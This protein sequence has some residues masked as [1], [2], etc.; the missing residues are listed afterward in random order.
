MKVDFFAVR[1]LAWKILKE[2]SL[3][4]PIDLNYLLKKLNIDFERAHLP[5]RVDGMALPVKFAR[6]LIIVNDGRL[7]TRERF[8]IAH[9]IGHILRHYPRMKQRSWMFFLDEKNPTS[10]P[11]YEREANIFATELLMPRQEV[12]QAFHNYTQNAEEL[13]NMFQ[14]SKQAMKIRL[15]EIKLIEMR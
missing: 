12:I 9:E 1:Q 4:V 6:G 14:V 7:K 3:K 15:E 13:A 5:S 10:L 8:T 2:Y 11:L